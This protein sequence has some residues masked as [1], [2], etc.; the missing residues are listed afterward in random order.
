MQQGQG[1]RSAGGLSGSVSG[2]A[3]AAAA[4]HNPA[5]PTFSVNRTAYLA[6]VNQALTAMTDASSERNLAATVEPILRA[7]LA[8][9]IWK[10]AQGTTSGGGTIQHP[11]GGVTLNLRL[12][13]NDAANPPMAGEFTHTGTTDGEMDIMVQRQ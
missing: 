10:D 3:P 8:R 4:D 6:L 5:G 11:V 1:D 2:A 9:V 13:P 12:I 7:M